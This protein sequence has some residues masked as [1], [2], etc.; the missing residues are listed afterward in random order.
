MVVYANTSAAVKARAHWMVTSGIALDVVR[1]LAARGEKL[2]GAPDRHLGH[3]VQKE[4][5]ADM[6]LWQAGCVVHEA[7]RAEALVEMKKRHPDAAVLVHPESPEPV[8]ELADVVGSTTGLIQ[9]VKSMDNPAFIVATDRG[10]FYKM[11]QAAPTKV[12]LEAP[13]VGEG[14][15]CVSCAHCPWMNMNSLAGLARVLE[16]G[17]NEITLNEDVR[18][19]ALGAIERLMRFVTGSRDD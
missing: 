18:G 4:T 7:F 12:L 1:H 9:A 13:T 6:L 5:G 19:K 10:I 14:A 16:T 11:R 15:S 17:E 8:V 3:W 2:M